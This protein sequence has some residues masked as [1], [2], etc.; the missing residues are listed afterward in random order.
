MLQTFP[1]DP[2]LVL[3]LIT[4]TNSVAAFLLWMRKPGQDASAEIDRFK[5]SSAAA[6]G[7]L[8]GRMDVLEE[9]VKHMPTSDELRELEGQ[10]VGIKAEM[11]SLKDAV[12]ATRSGVARIENWLMHE[13]T[14]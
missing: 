5:A 10:L 12:T 4:L 13:R 11:G 9:R 6:N 3:F 8:S 1:I 7:A 14:K 2:A